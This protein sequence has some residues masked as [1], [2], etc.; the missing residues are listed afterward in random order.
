MDVPI[1]D[2]GDLEEVDEGTKRNRDG[3]IGDEER[4]REDRKEEDPPDPSDMKMVAEDPD[5]R[6]EGS[7]PKVQRRL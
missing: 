4:A 7:A 1:P 6:E 3:E 5:E 2:A